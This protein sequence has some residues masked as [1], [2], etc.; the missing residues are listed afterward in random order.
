MAIILMWTTMLSIGNFCHP[1]RVLWTPHAEAGD[2]TEA[3]EI[4]RVERPQPHH[5]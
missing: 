5:Q 2:G 4:A 3:L 1:V